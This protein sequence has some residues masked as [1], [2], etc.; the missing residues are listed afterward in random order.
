MFR[1]RKRFRIEYAHVLESSYT[2]KCQSIHG[3]SGIIDVYLT[4]A[5]CNKDG[6]VVDFGKVKEVI[7]SIIDKYDHALLLHEDK[8][9]KYK[10]QLSDSK[11]IVSVPG[12]PTAELLACLL[13]M[14]IKTELLRMETLDPDVNN[15]RLERV[16]FHETESGW[17]EYWQ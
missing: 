8:V 11:K 3:H 12:N 17:A 1:I 10:S 6:M 9:D 2:E 14:E 5:Q 15:V 13:F 16:R 4:S 7:S